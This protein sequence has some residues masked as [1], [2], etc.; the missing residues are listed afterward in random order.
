MIMV[1]F[2]SVLPPGKNYGLNVNKDKYLF[3][4]ESFFLE[5]EHSV[6]E[7]FIVRVGLSPIRVGEMMTLYNVFFE[8]DSWELL[9][10]SLIELNKLYDLLVKNETI[11]IEIGGHTDSSGSDSHNQIL[12]QNRAESVKDFLISKG[13]DSGRINYK[14]FGATMPV[15]DNNT[16]EGMR[17][18]RRT[19][20]RITGTVKLP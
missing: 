8:T 4:S 20:I 17:R 18:N 16:R 9:S 14:G 2:L 12:S 3:F 5:G 19:E 10:E 15:S 6:A 13:I 7:P 11:I 1:N